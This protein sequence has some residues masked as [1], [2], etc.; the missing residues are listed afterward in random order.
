MRD[1]GAALALIPARGGSQGVPGK[2]IRQLA[3]KPLIAYSIASALASGTFDRV[4]VSTDNAE[5]AEIA[6]EHGADVIARPDE[7]AQAETP[8]APVIEHA[9]EFHRHERGSRPCH[10]FLLQPTSPFR[11]ADDI[12][13]AASILEGDDCDAVMGV[14]E[15]DDP[16]Q[17]ALRAGSDGMLGPLAEWEQYLARRQ[18]LP[19]SYLD[20]PLYAI[21][22][23]AFL[24][25][26]RFL[27][28]RTR[29]F[30]VPRLRAIDI[31]TE[32][33]FLF[34]EFLLEHGHVRLDPASRAP[35]RTGQA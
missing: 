1:C 26:E 5:T 11:S 20:G 27:T 17:W 15:A 14:F 16:P 31:D 2:N 8:M 18:D 13:R 23:E 10:I 25:S 34:A 21:E 12:R 4:Y 6:V 30:V 35:A 22:T 32:M 28:G 3:G 24:A 7:L 9:I 19:Q 33:D 29:F